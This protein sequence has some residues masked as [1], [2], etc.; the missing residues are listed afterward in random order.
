MSML[1]AKAT[2]QQKEPLMAKKHF[3][4]QHSESVVVQATA[5]IYSAYIASGRVSDGDEVAW[6]RRSIKEAIMLAQGVDDSVISD[7]EMDSMDGQDIGE[8]FV[9]RFRS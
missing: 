8:V 7:G 9:K 6:M 4:L 1:S 3:K 2:P 5:Q